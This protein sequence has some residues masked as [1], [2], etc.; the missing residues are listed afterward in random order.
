MAELA[1]SAV[2][3]ALTGLPNR[4][5]WEERVPGLAAACARAGTP[6]TVAVLDVDRFKALND[7]EGHLAGDR[8][9]VRI[10]QVLRREVRAED[11]VARW[12]GEEFALALPGCSA[13]EARVLLERVRLAVR[14]VRSCS[15]G[16][17]VRRGAEPLEDVLGRADA[18]L[19][20]AKQ[21]GRDVVLEA[22]A[23]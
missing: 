20:A 13:Q 23:V 22:P 6:L 14:P 8:L 2:T 18:A 21:A 1:A 7:S 9:L 5:A 15:V 3:D 10:A 12:G 4:R 17:A 16:F 19:Y 11:V